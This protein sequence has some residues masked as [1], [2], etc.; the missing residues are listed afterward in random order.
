MGKIAVAAAVAALLWVPGASQAAFVRSDREPEGCQAFNPGQPKC[1]W[2]FT[3]DTDSPVNGVAG[4]GTWIVKIKRGKKTEVIK[5][6]AYGEP[7]A[8]EH[9]FRKGDKVVA[10]AKSAG[11]G[12]VVG[13]VD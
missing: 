6:P 12:L 4:M 11:S 7:T 5:S 3:H 13:H 1:T 8:V 10:I 2:K 9:A